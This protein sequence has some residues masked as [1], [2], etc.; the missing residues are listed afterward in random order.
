M[1]LP[2]DERGEEKKKKNTGR[3]RRAEK[4]KRQKET[5]TARLSQRRLV[6]EDRKP[7]TWSSAGETR[8]PAGGSSL[9]A[10][11][12]LAV[13]DRATRGD[14]SQSGT[15]VN[16][17]VHWGKK[18]KKVIFRLQRQPSNMSAWTLSSDRAQRRQRSRIKRRAPPAKMSLRRS[19][20]IG[21]HLKRLGPHRSRLLAVHYYYFHKRRK[22]E[23]RT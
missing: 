17:R 11:S 2:R 15:D 6:R 12:L 9:R 5:E 20:F 22:K 14:F 16:L 8:D 18:K 23:V 19:F 3:G 4:D 21:F 7:A 1:S 13:T 10:T